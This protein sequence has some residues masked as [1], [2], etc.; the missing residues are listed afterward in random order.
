MSEE[1]R[2]IREKY[3][4]AVFPGKISGANLALV[5]NL[6]GDSITA[7]VTVAGGGNHQITGNNG[8]THRPQRLARE[9]PCV[10][11]VRFAVG[12]VVAGDAGRA[13]DDQLLVAV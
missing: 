1:T 4:R 10:P 9:L 2:Y 11:P 6:Q 3:F 5:A 12:R 8:R 7:A 13:G